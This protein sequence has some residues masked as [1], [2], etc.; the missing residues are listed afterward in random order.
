MLSSIKIIKNDTGTSVR[1]KVYP[2]TDPGYAYTKIWYSRISGP[3]WSQ[4][5]QED[6]NNKIL[7]EGL[8]KS[9]MY[10]FVPFAYNIGDEKDEPGL[11]VHAIPSNQATPWSEIITTLRSILLAIGM[12]SVHYGRSQPLIFKSPGALIETGARGKIYGTNEGS[13]E[14][15]PVTITIGMRRKDK[16][17]GQTSKAKMEYYAEQLKFQLDM[18]RDFSITDLQLTTAYISSVDD[19]SQAEL[20]VKSGIA[21]TLN[22]VFQIWRPYRKN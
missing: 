16:A 18:K 20:G 9:Q 21:A 22:I 17:T 12:Q 3:P 6:G 2:P 5:G 1:F 15:Y 10:V 4:S 13:L 8:T 7:V 11:P 14:G 19:W